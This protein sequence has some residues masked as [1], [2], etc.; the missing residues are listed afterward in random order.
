M[1]FNTNRKFKH[2]IQELKNFDKDPL[3][4]IDFG[5]NG[6]MAGVHKEGILEIVLFGIGTYDIHSR[7]SNKQFLFI[8]SL[9]EKYKNECVY[10]INLLDESPNLELIYHDFLFLKKKYDIEKISFT[11]PDFG[12]TEYIK[13]ISNKNDVIPYVSN[14]NMINHAGKKYPNEISINR[15]YFSTL[16]L[17]R[18]GVERLIFAYELYKKNYFNTNSITNIFAPYAENQNTELAFEEGELIKTIYDLNTKYNLN[19]SDLEKFI[20]VSKIGTDTQ[21]EGLVT[22]EQT[23]SIPKNNDSYFWVSIETTLDNDIIFITEKILKAFLYNQIPLVVMN[24]GSY[25]FLKDVGFEMDFDG[26]DTSFLES[27]IN[28]LDKIKKMARLVSELSK[29]SSDE[30]RELFLRN[31]K[32]VEKNKHLV[33][34]LTDNDNINEYIRYNDNM[35]YNNLIEKSEVSKFKKIFKIN[36]DNS[37]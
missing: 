18:F 22:V 4:K 37:K 26:I 21:S 19:Y 17:R 34:S 11:G 29:L 36:L 7:L 31:V 3:I 14:Y 28:D 5:G 25:K 20:E 13:K 2:F 8:E 23:R 1:N 32:K 16:L 12:A 24:A 10:S 15:K 33:L 30:I 27:N 6:I 35:M 9:F